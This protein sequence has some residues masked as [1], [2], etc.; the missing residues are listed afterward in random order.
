MSE[1]QS[2]S[3]ASRGR[4]SGRGSRGGG[5]STRASTR[6][7]NKPAATNGDS[8][9]DADS[10]LPTLDDEGD[11]G[12]LKQKYGSKIG[13]IKEMFSDWSDID[14]LYALQEADGDENLAVTRIADGVYFIYFAA[15]LD[16]PPSPPH[17]RSSPASLRGHC[18]PPNSMHSVTDSSCSL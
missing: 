10:S 6:P 9:H 7:S 15:S 12:E 11:V 8:K 18:S 16:C 3:A 14:I 5:Y 4:G 1:V 17:V 13:M 2:R